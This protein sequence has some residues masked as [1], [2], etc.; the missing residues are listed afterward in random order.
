MSLP[1]PTQIVL[2]LANFIGSWWWVCL[3]YIVVGWYVF[4]D[5]RALNRL[6]YDRFKLRIPLIGRLGQD[7]AVA[8]FTRTLGTLTSL[9]CRSWNPCESP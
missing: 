6:R 8:R 9:D 4:M 2:G 5:R 7:V 1:M 3:L